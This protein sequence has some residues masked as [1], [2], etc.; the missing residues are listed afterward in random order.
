MAIEKM[1]MVDIIGQKAD[2]DELTKSIIFSNCMHIVR[3]VKEIAATKKLDITEEK[4]AMHIR[5]ERKDSDYSVLTKRI[6][7]LM[8]INVS[9]R[10]YYAGENEIICDISGLE[11]AV[12]AAEAKFLSVNDKLNNKNQQ[13]ISIRKE[14]EKIKFIENLSPYVKN[15]LELRN[16]KFKVYK[17]LIDAFSDDTKF[18]SFTGVVLNIG[19]FDKYKI[20]LVIA[21][22]N[23]TE[24]FND[25]SGGANLEEIEIPEYYKNNIFF[26]RRKLQKEERV[27][28]SEIDGYE[29]EVIKICDENSE[30]INIIEQSLEFKLEAAKLKEK[31]A[32]SNEFFYMSGWVPK[33]KIR[34]LQQKVKK[35]EDKIIILEKNTEAFDSELVP[36]TKLKNIWLVRPFEKIVNLYG[37]PSY[38]EADPTV[39]LALTYMIMFGAMFG[40]LGQGIVLLL[41]GLFF[42]NKK[43]N[44]RPNLG[45]VLSRL[46]VSSSIFG[47]LYGS[48]FGFEDIIP[49]MLLRPMERISEMLM[50]AVVLGCILLT[51]GFVYSLINNAA[52][53]NAEEGIFG[54]NGAAGMLLYLSILA[55]IFLEYSKDVKIPV[56]IPVL[57]FSIL[58]VL[59]LFKQP[60]ANL[61]TRRRPLY[62]D[63]K[64]DYFI[65]GGFGLIETILGMLSNTISFIRIGAFALNHVGLFMAFSALAQ[66]THSN[67][68]GF[69]MYFLGN[70]VIL[71]LECLI[72]FIQ[73]LRL[74]YYELFG[75]YYD[76][77]GIPFEPA[78]IKTEK[79][80]RN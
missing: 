40:D 56:V 53:H 41:I 75:K 48:I 70:A 15:L 30:Q 24:D 50:L 1:I 17:C 42:I 64:L 44:S 55:F 62:S 80:N 23:T 76:G 18:D 47:V 27:L 25:Y 60:A 32:F 71:T 7:N 72:V 54:K 13:L 3:A 39:F 49:A 20:L 12:T 74:E 35:Y 68:G 4:L 45:G 31:G 73:G 57:V 43:R 5:E 11:K 63:S 65:E 8:N 14:F 9:K 79:I 19:K 37:I 78:A 46:G 29:A 22:L 2:F 6:N 59:I 67:F 52:K 34:E 36:P 21:P 33:S 77:S 28:I 61:L 26:I 69:I 16:F 38:K 10:K 51:A 66:M 58:L